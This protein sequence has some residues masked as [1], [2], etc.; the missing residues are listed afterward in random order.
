M[1]VGLK[2]MIWPTAHTMNCTIPTVHLTIGYHHMFLVRWALHKLEWVVE[3][4]FEQEGRG[5]RNMKWIMMCLRFSRARVRT[6]MVA[7]FAQRLL[8]SLHGLLGE[9]S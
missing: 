1:L 3:I 9:S 6:R 8:A 5:L 7:P 2:L 4:H